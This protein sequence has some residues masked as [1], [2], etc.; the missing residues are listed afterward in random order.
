[1]PSEFEQNLEKYAEVIV[2]VGLNIQPGQRLLIGP[3]IYGYLGVDLAMAPLVRLIAK[4]AYQAGARLVDVLW[5]D[6]QIE[7]IRMQHAP[8]DS[9]EEF[10][11]WRSDG[12]I[13]AAEAGDALLGIAAPDFDLFGDQDPDLKFTTFSTL[14]KHMKP[15]LKLRGQNSMNFAIIAAPISGWANKVFPDLPAD[16]RLTRFWDTVFEVCRVKQPDPVSAWKEHV[17]QLS[18]RA[19]HLSRRRYASLH[20]T[21]PGTDL[22]L[23]LPEG[24]IWHSARSTSQSGIDFVGNIPTEEI[25][26]IPHKDKTEGVVTSTKPIVLPQGVVENFSITFS[27]GKAVKAADKKGRDVFRSHFETDDNARQLG[28]VALVPHH[29][30]ISQSG[31]LFYMPLYDENASCHL[32]LG[33][34]YRNSIEGGEKMSD[35]EFV[36]AGG[37]ISQFH[38]DFM[39]GSKEMDINGITESGAAEQI[40]HGGEWAF[41]V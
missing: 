40:M 2:K 17:A 10:P 13:D 1:M 8:R 36:K 5:N 41:E 23:G 27:Q 25:Y 19:D 28:E 24:H 18:A 3:P 34:A 6:E 7:V 21:A 11:T 20:F 9:F 38:T 29:T 14:M 15:F 12:A 30:P 39:I 37:N 4:K 32:A 33:N 16:E 31:R 26:T 22:R 35:E